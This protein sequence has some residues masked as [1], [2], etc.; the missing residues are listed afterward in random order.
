MIT[1]GG[2][3]GVRVWQLDPVDDEIDGENSHGLD[4]IEV[5]EILSNRT[6]TSSRKRKRE[7]EQEKLSGVYTY[8]K[9]RYTRLLRKNHSD[10]FES[11]YNSSSL[12]SFSTPSSS[13]SAAS[14]SSP[15]S[16]SKPFR[17]TKYPS[18]PAPMTPK[19]RKDECIVI[20]P[21]S[22][23]SSSLSSSASSFGDASSASSSVGEND[24]LHSYDNDSQGIIHWLGFDEGRIVGVYGSQLE[25]MASTPSLPSPYS[26]PLS[27][28]SSVVLS[29]PSIKGKD[30]QIIE[31][32]EEGT[33]EDVTTSEHDDKITNNET[34]KEVVKVK[35]WDFWRGVH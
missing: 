3:C 34:R 31:P 20:L 21:H 33:K 24:I 30:M 23:P 10:D 26:S 9:K 6:E 27:S 22:F 4:G 15:L 35:I 19:L 2:D 7:K 18:N 8:K 32:K 5:D 25:I 11:E 13:R 16:H 12:S 29:L 28:S 14:I 1:S 17:N